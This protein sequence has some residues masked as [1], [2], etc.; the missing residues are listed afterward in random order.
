[1]TARKGYASDAP[2]YTIVPTIWSL[3]NLDPSRDGKDEIRKSYKQ[4]VLREH[5]DTREGEADPEFV[6]RFNMVTK[7]YKKIMKT[8]DDDFWVHQFDARVSQDVQRKQEY[9][10]ARMDYRRYAMELKLQEAEKEAAEFAR[11]AKEQG[12]PL[13]GEEKKEEGPRPD[14]ILGGVLVG[15]AGTLLFA[16]VA[17]IVSASG[18]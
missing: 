9:R 1:V 3:L 8:S 7:E 18:S 13:P 11:I 16:F 2:S 5:P 17:V 14:E 4:F 10:Q 6:Q 15:G 12:L